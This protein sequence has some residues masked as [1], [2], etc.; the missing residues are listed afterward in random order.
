MKQLLGEMVRFGLVGLGATAVHLGV[1]WIAYRLAGVPP[2]WANG[3]AFSIAFG[4][5]Y[6]GHS[7]WTF[8]R[9]GAHARSLPR[10]LIIAL[11]GY[12]LSNVLIWLIVTELGRPFEIALLGILF[13]VPASTWLMARFWAFRHPS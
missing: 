7:S 9:R 3:I 4:V 10:F 1:A 6:L 11:I 13:V 5:S 8:G 12:A 2:Y